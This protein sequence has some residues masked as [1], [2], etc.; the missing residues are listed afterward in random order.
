MDAK[1]TCQYD[2]ADKKSVFIGMPVF[3]AR[4][5]GEPSKAAPHCLQF[6]FLLQVFWLHCLQIVAVKSL[7]VL[8]GQMLLLR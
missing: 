8:L 3:V 2:G 4:S 7:S 6:T 5:S 1:Q